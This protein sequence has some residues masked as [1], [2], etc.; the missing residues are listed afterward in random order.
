MESE[1]R[2]GLGRY[3]TPRPLSQALVDWAVRCPTDE[4]LEPSSGCGVFVA[5]VIHRLRFLGQARPEQQIWACDIDPL[6]C[7]QTAC[8]NNLHRKHIWNA[9]FLSLVDRDGFA[10]RKFDC[11]AGNPP[12]ISL[13]RMQSGQRKRAIAAAKRIGF[14]IDKRASLWAYFAVAAT[15]ALRDGGR[16]ALILP[17][18][19]LH[20]DY[21]RGMLQEVGRYFARCLLVSIRE[22]CFAPDGA[23]ERVVI[24][25]GEDFQATP[26]AAEILL[27]EFVTAQE[28]GRFLETFT[29]ESAATL[30]RLNGH[31][32]PH[33][34]PELLDVAINLT[35]I[36]AS[37][38]LGDFAEIKIGVVT[39]ANE[40]FLLTEL[41]RK[42]WKLSPSTVVPVLPRFQFCKGLAF[43]KSDWERLVNAGE[44]CWLLSPSVRDTSDAVVGYMRR[45]PKKDREENR[46]FAKRRP[47]YSPQLGEEP[48]AFLRYMGAFGPR[49]ALARCEATCTNTVHRVYFKKDVVA[50]RRKAIALSLHSSF[51]Q[52]SAEFEGRAYGSGVL[53]LEP[54]EAKRLR[55]LLPQKLDAESLYKCFAVAEGQIARGK[56]QAAAA[57]IDEWLYTS[58]PMLN[59][60]L[61]LPNLRRWLNAS[62]ERRVGYPQAL[63]ARQSVKMTEQTA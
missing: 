11:I 55:L 28:A 53:K 13:H 27:R 24:F 2:R 12:Y 29:P 61:P 46:T 7:A 26:A 3:D 14:T 42:K 33:L 19:I 49:L 47:W 56:I 36:P 51:S 57:E 9:D 31:A 30:P 50:L 8:S 6:A 20:A 39:G 18:S 63:R 38:T 17:E 35:Q 54:S 40:F 1:K 58:I 15:Q 59:K 45:F 52:L 21:A 41:E 48:D 44:K 62:V 16:L 37:S 5:S 10:K 43:R 22:R 23:A 34:L 32:V 4:V 60:I 25:L